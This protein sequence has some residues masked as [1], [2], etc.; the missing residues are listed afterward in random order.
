VIITLLISPTFFLVL[1]GHVFHP[2]AREELIAEQHPVREG[3]D[4]P[5]RGQRRPQTA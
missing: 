4:G 5:E 3:A 2:S 1:R